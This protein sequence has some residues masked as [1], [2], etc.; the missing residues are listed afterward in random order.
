MFAKI[1]ETVRYVGTDDRNLDLFES[2]YP[3]PDGMSYNSYLLL[4]EKI[5]VLDTADAREGRRWLDNL[6]EALEGREPDYLVIHHMEPDHSA[7]IA[8]AL[9]KYPSMTLVCSQIAARM[10]PQFFGDVVF[11]GR[12]EIVGEGASLSLGRNTLKFFMAPMVHWPEVMVSWLVEEKMLFSADAFGTFGTVEHAGGLVCG[13]LSSWEDEAARYYFNICGKYGAQVGKLLDKLCGLQV[14]L[15]C[16]LHGPVL[17]DVSGAVSR[18][19]T[20]SS[21]APEREAVLVAYA[22]IHGGTAEAARR[23]SA[24]LE[25]KGMPVILRDLSRTDV[26]YSVSDAFRCSKVVFAASSYDA[27]VFPPMHDFIWH[28]QIKG[29]HKR[30]AALVQNGSWSPTA[31]RIMCEMLGTMKDIEIVAD[32]LTIRS[33]MNTCDVAS[34][35]ALSDALAA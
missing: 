16:P 25:K 31:G 32:V 5:A 4:D 22:S 26:S 35:E 12:V 8:A 30:K 24:M 15:I 33:R 9:E 23:L 3:V 13:D 27:G 14:E 2:Q 6:E 17:S 19:R 10:L 7:M 18:Y 28:L 1:S 21:G 20:W 34:L 11:D 29:W